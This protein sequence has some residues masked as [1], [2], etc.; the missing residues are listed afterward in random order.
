MQDL[1]NATTHAKKA[2][3]SQWC[4][5]FGVNR[6]GLYAA[7]SRHALP[8]AANVLARQL[9]PEAPNQAWASDITYVCTRSGWLYLAVVLDLFSRRLAGWSMAPSMPAQLVCA[10]LGM[11]IAS[12]QLL[13]GLYEPKRQ[14]LG[15]SIYDSAER[16]IWSD[17]CWHWCYAFALTC[18]P[19][20]SVDLGTAE[21]AASDLIEA[22][23]CSFDE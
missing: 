4:R 21:P 11:A 20:C 16:C 8:V 23:C 18:R 7:D 17:P 19:D 6:S 12:R 14:L 10:A 5:I 22:L 15:Y 2:T 13:P 1:V 3:V 9:N